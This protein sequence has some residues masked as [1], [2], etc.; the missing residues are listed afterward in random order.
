MTKPLDK[1]IFLLMSLESERI[2]PI[3]RLPSELKNLSLAWRR[4]SEHFAN[5]AALAAKEGWEGDASSLQH[6]A[7]LI[8]RDALQAAFEAGQVQAG[9]KRDGDIPTLTVAPDE[10]S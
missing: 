5:L 4:Q 6:L 10:F 7:S 8:N 3:N 1:F 9:G 2:E